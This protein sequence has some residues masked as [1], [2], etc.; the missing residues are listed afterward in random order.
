[1]NGVKEKFST[2]VQT[3]KCGGSLPKKKNYLKKK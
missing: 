1:M 3:K 2:D